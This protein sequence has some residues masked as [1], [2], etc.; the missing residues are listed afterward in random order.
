MIAVVIL[1]RFIQVGF[2]PLKANMVSLWF[3][4][5]ILDRNM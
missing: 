5:K 3:I 4:M 1:H 2:E